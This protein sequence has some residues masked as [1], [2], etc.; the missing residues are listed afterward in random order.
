MCFQFESMTQPIHFY[1]Q[2]PPPFPLTKKNKISSSLFYFYFTDVI[3]RLDVWT[4]NGAEQNAQL[5][6]S[7][8]SPATFL[9]RADDSTS[10]PACMI[11]VTVDLSKPREA[12]SSAIRWLNVCSQ[13]VR[14]IMINDKDLIQL[15]KARE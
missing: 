10:K 14:S 9:S 6:R 13:L 1:I 4:V 3:S 5:L 7:V 2:T 8:L 11:V 15:Q 12:K